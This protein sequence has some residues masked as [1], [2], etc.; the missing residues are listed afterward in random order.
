MALTCLQHTGIRIAA[1]LASFVVGVA[2]YNAVQPATVVM[3]DIPTAAAKREDDLHRLYEAVMLSGDNELRE[4]ITLRLMYT[5]ANDLEIR[6]SLVS[7]NSERQESHLY[8]ES[9]LSSLRE[10]HEAWV[11]QNMEFIR[12]ISTAEKARAYASEHPH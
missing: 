2:T 1:L 3:T 5:D 10:S 9:R 7:L 12:E 6:A 8:F 11:Q 4:S